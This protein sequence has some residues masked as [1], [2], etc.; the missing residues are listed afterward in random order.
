MERS[1]AVGGADVSRLPASAKSEEP[2]ASC[3]RC[4]HHNGESFMR[5]LLLWLI[6]VPIPVIIILWLITG[7]A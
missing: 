4:H 1:G 3:G 7:H 5:S 6:G 2:I